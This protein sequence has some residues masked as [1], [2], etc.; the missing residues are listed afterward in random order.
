ML[1]MIRTFIQEQGVV[2]DQLLQQHFQIEATALSPILEILLARHEI[3]EVTADRC[4]QE[5]HG[6]DNPSYYQ[7]TVAK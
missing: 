4:Q 2:S 6:C 7:W 1:V 5:C 3:E